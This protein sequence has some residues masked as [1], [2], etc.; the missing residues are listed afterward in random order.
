MSKALLV[1]E[2]PA[3]ARTLSKYL[4]RDYVVR[5]TV[6]HIKDLPTNSLGV[7]VQRDFQPTYQ[8]I[9][10]KGKVID[11]IRDAANGVTSVFLASDPDREGEAIAW[12]VAEEI[13]RGRSREEVPPFYRVLL[14]EITRAGLKRALEA[15]G[16]LDRK[17]Y[18]SQLAR[19]IL[20]RLVG[21]ELSP[22][23]WKKV[24]GGLSAGRVQS[25]AVA[26]VVDRE[27]EI[28]GF[29]PQEYWVI[30]ST[31]KGRVPPPFAARLTRVDGQKAEI[32][33]EEQARP[34]IEALKTAS[35][36]VEAVKREEKSRYAPPPFITSTLQQDAHRILHFSAKKTMSLAQRLYEGVDL[37]E[38]GTAGLIT[39][40][41][42]D[43]LRVADEAVAA[44]RDHV[45][46]AFGEAYVPA[47]PTRFK[48]R[49][50]A[51]DAHEAIRPT[52]MEFAPDRVSKHLERDMARLYALIWNRFVASQ[53]TAARF[54]VTTVTIGAGARFTMEATG[55][56]LLFDG[57]LRAFRDVEADDGEEPA[58]PPLS[59]KDALG[60]AGVDGEQN[61]TQPPPR[62]TEGTLVK[63]LE[64]LGI[65]RPS[66]YATILSTIE[67]KKYVE[68]EKGRFKPTDLGF[69]VTDLLRENFP[70]IMDVQFTAQ[71]EEELDRIEEGEAERVQVLDKFWGGFQDLL[72]AARTEMKS[73]KQAPE[74]TDLA[75]PRCAS[76]LVIRFG[77]NGSFLACSSFP[78]CRTTLPFVRGEDGKPMMVKEEVSTEKCESCGADV[79][80]KNGR[81]GRFWACVNYPECKYTKPYSTGF[82]CP[83]PGCTGALVEKRSKKNSTFYRCS[84]RE[85]DTVLFGRLKSTPCPSCSN[86]FMEEKGRGKEKSTRC[87]RCG[88]GGAAEAAAE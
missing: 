43:S 71:M 59:E 53:M 80:L 3:K 25:V 17:R 42:T 69:V 75:C 79:V 36:A 31:L 64:K 85:C 7:A 14:H 44:V 46:A 9:R 45:R 48:N 50:S 8:L 16:R 29:K 87:P 26:L 11:A 5:A 22:L 6:G 4:G 88:Y 77:K 73:V 61:F 68:K 10:G 33:N 13:S 47:S 2:S 1:V 28:L 51:Q 56:V 39:Y 18:E 65:G 15:P 19:R 74:K 76:P 57:F 21:Y 70:Q 35:Y 49:K 63:D 81:F 60:L 32:G 24:S 82:A 12:H 66:T 34:I 41:R 62:F 40:M 84:V 72:K 54:D 27:R 37:G 78:K 52:S 67:E 58:L 38:M 86:T 30:T 55:R 23:L 20:D 83:R